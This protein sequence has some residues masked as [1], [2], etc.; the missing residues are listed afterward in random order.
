MQ[1]SDNALSDFA[2]AEKLDYSND[3]YAFIRIGKHDIQLPY[4]DSSNVKLTKENHISIVQQL[5]KTFASLNNVFG[6]ENITP[7]FK[8]EVND[9]EEEVYNH[10]RTT[11][12]MVDYINHSYINFHNQKTSSGNQ[13]LEERAKTRRLND[14]EGRTIRY[15]FE[16]KFDKDN[17]VFEA[18]NLLPGL[19]YPKQHQIPMKIYNFSDFVALIEHIKQDIDKHFLNINIIPDPEKRS[20]YISLSLAKFVFELKPIRKASLFKKRKWQSSDLH[21][22]KLAAEGLNTGYLGIFYANHFFPTTTEELRQLTAIPYDMLDN[23]LSG[24]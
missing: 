22:A 7:Y 17:V 23:I 6:E 13:N 19:A 24:K 8:I 14:F 10:N 4:I 21:F 15:L 11:V 9:I 3:N 18:S 2:I 5:D 12:A 1:K 20:N 16:V